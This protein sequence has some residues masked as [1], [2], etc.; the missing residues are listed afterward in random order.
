M[1]YYGD[2]K[3][4]KQEGVWHFLNRLLVILIVFAF[5]TLIICWFLPL[6]RKQREQTT[7]LEDLKKGFEAQKT[8]LSLRTKQ[9]DLLKNDP[10]YV[11]VL[12]RDRLD[13]MKPDET[14]FRLE[15]H[16]SPGASK[17]KLHSQ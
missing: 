8:R 16:A 13:M 2:Y 9:V 1:S 10:S 14:I 6:L 11:E 3:Q 12:A 17:L 15:S 7:R 4:R 5:V